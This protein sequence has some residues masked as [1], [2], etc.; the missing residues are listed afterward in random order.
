MIPW[1]AEILLRGSTA[2]FVVAG[3]AALQEQ[4]ELVGQELA[5][6]GS[7]GTDTVQSCGVRRRG[8]AEVHR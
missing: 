1:Y 5:R 7:S 3:F 4:S 2:Q 6:I 8:A